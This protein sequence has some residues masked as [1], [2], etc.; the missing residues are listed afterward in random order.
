MTGVTVS[1]A[2]AARAGGRAVARGSVRFL[3][4]DWLANDFAAASFDR[5]YAIESSEHMEDKQL[6]FDEAF[7]T[8]KPGRAARGLRLARRRRPETLAGAPPARTDLPG[9]APAEHG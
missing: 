4:R 6:F 5:A 1:A 7:R 9:G 2:Q 3:Q 8:L